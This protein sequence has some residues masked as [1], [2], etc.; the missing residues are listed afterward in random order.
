MQERGQKGSL[1]LGPVPSKALVLRL[2]S[3]GL[4]EPDHPPTL[5]SRKLR[6]YPGLL[7]ALGA[8]SLMLGL[9][10]GPQL[11]LWDQRQTV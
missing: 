10:P 2:V 1:Q 7:V 8:P 9:S 3:K 11:K 6:G 5:P 4:E